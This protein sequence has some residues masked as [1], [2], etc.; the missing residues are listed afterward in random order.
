MVPRVWFCWV[1][2]FLFVTASSAQSARFASATIRPSTMSAG[3]R[4]V[5][6][7]DPDGGY[8]ANNVT[9]IQLI[10]AAYRRSGYDRREIVGGPDW[11]R[12]HRFDLYA[13]H[14]GEPVLDADGFPRQTL[15]ML[16]ELL[17]ER[18]QIRGGVDP[19]ERQVYALMSTGGARPRLLPST[20]DC[21]A[22][23]RAMARREQISGAPCGAAP[24]PG[25]LMARG[26]TITDL[27]NLIAPWVDKPVIDRTGL[28]GM[29]DVDLE[30]AEFQPRG[31]F[32]PSYRPSDTKQSVFQLMPIQLGLKLEP[33]IATIEVLVVESAQ[34]LTQ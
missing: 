22:Q 33:V 1:I 19:Q 23:I 5:S 7:V 25:R 21:A 14:G 12:T 13:T 6:R 11:V 28:S 29:F 10:E 24:Y 9:L 30:G 2:G 15:R 3:E 32:G 26:V 8:T 16:Q 4:S 18:F 20:V 31:P 17:K 27:A 34:R